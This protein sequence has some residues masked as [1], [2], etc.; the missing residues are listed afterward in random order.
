[1][2]IC[3]PAYNA[4]RTLGA[5]LR[6][7]LGQTY[8]NL[9]VLVVDDASTDGTADVARAFGPAVALHRNPINLGLRANFERC[10]HLG[11]G[12]YRALFHADDIY[13]PHLV[14]TQV[15]FLEQHPSVGAAF[16]SASVID[17][18]GR[19]TGETRTFPE[20]GLSETGYAIFTLPRLVRMLLARG[21]FLVAPSAMVRSPAYAEVEHWGCD[22]SL[23]PAAD[24]DV[25]LQIAS[26]RPI[27]LLEERLMQYRQ[28][29]GQ[30]SYR[31]NR[32]R[33]ERAEYL[34]VMDR[35][36][37]HPSVR[38]EL[39]AADL[40]RKSELERRDAIECAARALLLGRNELARALLLRSRQFRTSTGWRTSMKYL[41]LEYA[42][43][44]GGVSALRPICSAAL[45]RGLARKRL[46]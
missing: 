2:T 22:S 3:V 17:E 6:S 9:E 42:T 10:M 14:A 41:A 12:P 1:V 43:R 36:L 18:S 32:T 7:L 16:A 33:V 26:A 28:S 46:W 40:L 8:E 21:N 34:T 31:Y 5:T 20:L 24:L 11:H 13:E 44:A 35:W 19:K 15:A 25:W 4:A 27:A 38:C 39:T 37:E 30:H 23:G 29:S 45:R